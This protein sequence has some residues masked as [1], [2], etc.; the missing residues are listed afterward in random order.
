[1]VFL[2]IESENEK[3]SYVLRKNPQTSPHLRK[4]RAGNLIG[5]FPKKNEA[6]QKYVVRFVD[7][8][9]KLSFHKSHDDD[10]DYLRGTEFYHPLL[11]PSILIETFNTTMNYGDKN[12]I[13]EDIVSKCEVTQ[14]MM[15]LSNR[16]VKL[17]NRINQQMSDLHRALT[18]EL[19]P[20]E[21]NDEVIPCCYTV[22]IGGVC[23]LQTLFRYAYMVGHIMSYLTFGKAE[24]ISSG[25]VS[26]IVRIV[27]ELDI[28]YYVRYL[29]K[30]YLI[31]PS[32]LD[33]YVDQL[34]ESENHQLTLFRGNTQDQRYDFIRSEMDM[35]IDES[36]PSKLEV[37]DIGCGE[38]FYVKKLIKYLNETHSEIELIYHAHDIDPEEMEKIERIRE[39]DDSYGE[40]LRPHHTFDELSKAVSLDET[41]LKIVVM[42]E[43]IEHV[44]L[45]RVE[46]FITKV[47]GLS[48]HKAILTTPDVDF[49]V[50]YGISD[51]DGGGPIEF[52]HDDHKKEYTKV[53]FYDLVTRAVGAVRTVS[54][55]T[56]FEQKMVGDIVDSDSVSQ[57]IIV[58]K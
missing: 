16:A 55:S 11:L 47:V 37:I 34:A 12:R 32:D 19:S 9:E 17:I 6:A 14:S 39:I 4:L 20:I 1:M 49:N 44:P 18:I 58:T 42:S 36:S 45:D 50:H 24:P 57:A 46:N 33:K 25:S 8:K 2:V 48:F 51:R 28:P 10:T 54:A 38:G 43:V 5:F 41:S 26:K 35:F 31:R 53:E 56:T 27:T 40:V 30:T 15:Y 29:L 23:R 7:S 22:K 21:M 52:R 3:T 13:E